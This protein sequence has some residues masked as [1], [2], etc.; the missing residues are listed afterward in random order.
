[1]TG[2]DSAQ[3]TEF[4]LSPPRPIRGS[5]FVPPWLYAGRAR[6]V[7][8]RAGLAGR[9]AWLGTVAGFLEPL[10]YLLAVGV[11]LGSVIGQVHDASGAPVSYLAFV[12]PGLLAASTMNAAVSETTM[13]VFFKLR[14]ARLYE[15]MVAT[16]LAAG[17][18]VLGEII[19]AGLSSVL[20]AMG[21][22]V[23]LSVLGLLTTP[24]ALAAIP[25]AFL[26]GTGFGAAGMACTSFMRSWEDSQLV[27]LVTV[28]MMLFSTTFY[29]LTVYPAP[30]RPVIEIL[31]LYQGIELMRA[32]LGGVPG[33]VALGHVA[34]FAAVV[35]VAGA[36]AVRRLDRLLLH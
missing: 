29:P 25:A 31:P 7:L 11:G 8:L 35:A 23:A 9:R 30:L 2:R 20:Y 5:R 17:D 24:L 18:V 28:P 26:I 19:W 3:V 36:I 12:V 10:F 33:W 27:Q 22:L 15:S 13:S 14:H 6:M 4:L 34:Y 21:F 1:M 16:P 32:L